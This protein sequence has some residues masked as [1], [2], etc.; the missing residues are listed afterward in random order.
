MGQ[1]HWRAGARQQAINIA[2]GQA[3]SEEESPFLPTSLWLIYTAG[4]L[5]IAPGRSPSPG[6]H[7]LFSLELSVS[8][9]T[10]PLERFLP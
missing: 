6:Q 3:T 2:A 8:I 5:R 1:R 10:S 7:A 4:L 9:S